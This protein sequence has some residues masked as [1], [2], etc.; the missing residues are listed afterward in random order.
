MKF[1]PLNMNMKRMF[2]M[3]LAVAIVTMA[4]CEKEISGCM[5]G[6]SGD[7][8]PDATMEDGSCR[9]PADLWAGTYVAIDSGILTSSATGHQEIDVVVKAMTVERISNNRVRIDSLLDLSMTGKVLPNL[10]TPDDN[11][12]RD[13]EAFTCSRNGNTIRYTYFWNFGVATYQNRGT[14]IRQ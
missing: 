12:Y 6:D 9:Y 13:F 2:L 10:F 8:N 7:Y 5:D 14:A 3:I 1:D 4:S 11:P